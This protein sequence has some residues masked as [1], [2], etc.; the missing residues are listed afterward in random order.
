MHKLKVNKNI[1]LIGFIILFF[2]MVTFSNAQHLIKDTL[3]SAQAVQADNLSNIYVKEGNSLLK[4]DDKGNLEQ[5]FN[6]RKYGSLY[7]FDTGNPYKILLFYKDFGKI[8]ILD[9]ML[10]EQSVIDLQ[11]LAFSN[12]SI[13]AT[14]YQ[15]GFW[16]YDDIQKSLIRFNSNS[17]IVIKTGNLE[18]LL[19]MQIDPVMMKEYNDKLYLLLNNGE[20]LVFDIF[21]SYLKTI[22][23]KDTKLIQPMDNNLYFL[24]QNRLSRFNYKTMTIQSDTLSVS[25]VRYFSIQKNIL[26]L[27]TSKHF[28]IYTLK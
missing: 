17:K 2:S 22:S 11:M 13:A 26:A 4:F 27:L 12:V 23:L 7:S 5:Q 21:G 25:N 24:N 20:V 10:S 18:Q 8:V 19:N 15:D 14:S 3:L 1:K 28:Y 9:N 6:T 16:I